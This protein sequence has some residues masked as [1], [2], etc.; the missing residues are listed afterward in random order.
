MLLTALIGSLLIGSPRADTDTVRITVETPHRIVTD[1]GAGGYQAFPDVCRLKN[2]DLLCVF[3]AG[4]GHVSHPSEKLPKGGRISAVR[5]TDDGA[6]WSAPWTIIDTPDDDRDPSVCCL[7]DGTLLCNFFTYGKR[8]ECDTCI[9]RSTD[10]G[11]TWS[12]PRVVVPSFATSTPIRRLRSGRLVLPVYTVDGVGGKRAYAAVCLSDDGG[13]RWSSPRPIGLKAGKTID[14]TDVLERKDGT[15]VSFSRE[16][17]VGSVSK[18]HGETWGPV[19]ELGFPGH[20]PYLLTTKS[21]VLLMA[22]RVPKTSLH[23]SLDEGRTWH[24][25]VQIDDVI[26]AYPSMVELRDGR[27]LCVYYEEGQNSAIRAATIRVD[28]SR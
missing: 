19:Y 12:E 17:M 25:P 22:H 3:Y 28:R 6:T 26:G 7:P 16:V 18:D 11:K 10:G 4:Y 20:C 2:G 8:T 27:V 13:K 15:L 14:E 23:W 1:V 9:A 21:G 5:S 24:G